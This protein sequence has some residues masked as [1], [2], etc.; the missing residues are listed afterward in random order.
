MFDTELEN[1]GEYLKKRIASYEPEPVAYRFG[2]V[3]RT[4]DGVVRVAGL[5]NRRYGELLEFE[6]GV[7]GMTL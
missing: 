2:H 3:S 4:G 6:G 5:P 7:Y 1:L